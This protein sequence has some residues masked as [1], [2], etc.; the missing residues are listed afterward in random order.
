MAMSNPVVR[1]SVLMIAV[2]AMVACTT[3]D[4]PDAQPV[5]TGLVAADFDDFDQAWIRP[6]FDFSGYDAVLIEPAEIE[7]AP[8]WE[9]SGERTGSRLSQTMADVEGTRAE[10]ID[11]IDE[12]IRQAVRRD[13]RF[14]VVETPGPGVLRLRPRVDDLFITA[15]DPMKM[16]ARVDQY[17]RSVGHGL[18]GLEVAD[19]SSGEVLMQFFDRR[20]TRRYEELRLAS[21]GLVATDFIDWYRRFAVDAL[22][23]LP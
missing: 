22:N 5:P 9:R 13:D 15:I 2:C 14:R 19:A 20:E 1:I 10:M 18:A 11:V 8:D 17:V 16:A 3:M 7:F 23:T 12:A 4:P 6:D 21:P